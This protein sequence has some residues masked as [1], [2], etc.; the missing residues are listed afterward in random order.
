MGFIKY[1]FKRIS[2]KG[3]I[4]GIGEFLVIVGL[5]ILFIFVPY[6]SFILLLASLIWSG[7]SLAMEIGTTNF[8]QKLE[9]QLTF[10][11]SISISM[12]VSGVI[13]LAF[14]AFFL[15]WGL[16]GDWIKGVY[17]DYKREKEYKE[18]LKKE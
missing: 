9:S 18:S 16:F 8:T 14:F 13:I 7:S 3:I 11:E 4:K 10:K 12:G 15:L 5:G 17:F 6:V 1:L 2:L